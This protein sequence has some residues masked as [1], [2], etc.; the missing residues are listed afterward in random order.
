MDKSSADDCRNGG[1]VPKK[2]NSFQLI[3]EPNVSVFLA[4]KLKRL[5]RAIFLCPVNLN[6]VF[7]RGLFLCVFAYLCQSKR[8]MV[9]CVMHGRRAACILS[10]TYTS[11]AKTVP[12]ANT[13]GN[14]RSPMATVSSF[15]NVNR[16]TAEL[17]RCLTV[18][19]A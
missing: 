15:H 1:C 18:K 13:T 10:K 4:H 6:S 12:G 5:Q 3:S 9:S 8:P 19:T 2:K 11:I 7:L 16:A 14:P 17:W